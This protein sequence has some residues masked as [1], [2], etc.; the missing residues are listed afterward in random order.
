M[1]DLK[2]EQK[3][4]LNRPRY[5]YSFAAKLFFFTMDLITGKK[6][7]LQ[8]AKLIEMLASIPYRAWEYRQYGKMTRQYKDDNVVPK[9]R[10]IMLWGRESQ[11]NEYWH[12][13]V[14]NE[15]MREDNVKDSWY[16]FP[17]IPFFMVGTYNLLSR[18]LAFFNIN[19]AFL[20]NAEFEDHAEHVY[21]QFVEEHPEWDSQ[22]VNSNIVPGYGN[23]QTWGEVFRRIGLDERDHMNNSFVY[24]GK[25]TD[26]VKYEGMPPLP[27]I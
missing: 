19:R 10:D 14:I 2:H 21:A 12:L 26:V 22:P 27:V 8:K 1:I 17:V 23:F 20:F 15:K 4:S 7:T 3:A 16:L 25:P 24:C 11:D 9:A 13:L 5:K 18:A 6:I